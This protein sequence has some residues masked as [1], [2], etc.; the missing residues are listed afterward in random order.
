M[1]KLSSVVCFPC[2]GLVNII[3]NSGKQ[4]FIGTS[5]YL[6]LYFFLLHFVMNPFFFLKKKKQE[7]FPFRPN[8]GGLTNLDKLEPLYPSNP[9]SS[10]IHL[11]P[12]FKVFLL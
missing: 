4:I 8:S 10:K 3:T 11:I 2:V 5:G 7:P 1:S 9:P 12:L 6:L